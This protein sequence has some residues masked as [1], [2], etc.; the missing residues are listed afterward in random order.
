MP[1]YFV[2]GRIAFDDEDTG[3]IVEADNAADAADVLIDI[4]RDN[5]GD[6]EN[7]AFI[8]YVVD[9]GPAKP[10]IVQCPQ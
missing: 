7:E 4:M 5:T 6:R 2:T 1:F 3:E 10:Q 8:N 9:C